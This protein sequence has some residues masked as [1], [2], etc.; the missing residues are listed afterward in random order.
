MGQIFALDR[1]SFSEFQI[2][3]FKIVKML[4]ERSK[5][6]NEYKNIKGNDLGV[7]SA[8]HS[9]NT[10]TL[11]GLKVLSSPNHFGMQTQQNLIKV[12]SKIL[13]SNSSNS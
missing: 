11:I 13:V 7:E 8:H 9:Q 1:R 4:L 5:K 3:V 6:T 12:V 10:K 2:Q